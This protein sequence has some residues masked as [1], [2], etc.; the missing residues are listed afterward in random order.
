MS[1]ASV[2][3]PSIGL[4]T[5]C[6]F[7]VFGVFGE[8]GSCPSIRPVT[9]PTAALRALRVVAPSPAPEADQSQWAKTSR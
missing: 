1:T 5:V 7:G 3:H 9:L 4:S 6:S 2:A 8:R